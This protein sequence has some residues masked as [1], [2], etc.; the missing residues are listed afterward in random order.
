MVRLISKRWCLG[1]RGRL[2]NL[3]VPPKG[4][5]IG[6]LPRFRFLAGLLAM[7]GWLLKLMHQLVVIFVL[8][9]MTGRDHVG[10]LVF[11][12]SNWGSGSSPQIAESKALAWAARL[13]LVHSWLDMDSRSDA[14][15]VIKQ[16]VDGS[17][18]GGWETRNELMF[19]QQLRKN[20]RRQS[21][22]WIPRYA[23][24][25][26]NAAAKWAHHY[27]CNLEISNNFVVLLLSIVLSFIS[28]ERSVDPSFV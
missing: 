14:Q 21:Y 8:W 6:S 28:G 22:E 25:C 9:A 19:L 17:D 26:A 16:V 7:V 20:L 23:N 4:S 3:G 2:K 18:P 10:K 1:L 27:K 13:A 11:F 24:L 15:L 5:C 12:A